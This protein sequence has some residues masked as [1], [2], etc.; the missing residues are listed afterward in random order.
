MPNRDIGAAILP[1]LP[2]PMSLQQ[3]GEH[4]GLTREV[5]LAWLLAFR[6]YLLDVD[7]SGAFEIQVRLGDHSTPPVQCAHCGFDGSFTSAGFDKKGRRRVCCPQCGRK[8]PVDAQHDEASTLDGLIVRAPID[9]AVSETS[10]P[11]APKEAEVPQRKI[12][13]GPLDQQEDV[14]LTAFLMSWVHEALSPSIAAGPCPK[15]ASERT[16]YYE[17]MK[18]SGLPS[19]KCRDCGGYF[20]RITHSPLLR[21]RARTLAH[22][23]IPMLGWRNTAETAARALGVNAAWIEASVLAWRK[24]LMRLDPSG[25][26]ES[27][28][29]L[30][31]PMDLSPQVRE[32]IKQRN[33]WLHRAWR[34]GKD[35]F[36]GLRSD[37]FLIRVGETEG[38]WCYEVQ[39]LRKKTRHNG[40]GF[41]SIEEA[42]LAAFDYVTGRLFKPDEAKLVRFLSTQKMLDRASDDEKIAA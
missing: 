38:G 3:A 39:A 27:R 34:K 18:A 23:L 1:L 22:R 30:D 5:V 32:R 31:L 16:A 25:A 40:E 42:R 10:M 24:H 28:V 11:R 17:V 37:G 9:E 35:G 6:S 8:R 20:S 41:R 33:R 2:N 26:M 21:A 7:P 14:A 4:L 15:C 19:F 36:S 29:R 13:P 12:T